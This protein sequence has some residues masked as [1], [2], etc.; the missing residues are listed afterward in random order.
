MLVG[1]ILKSLF[2]LG[3][4]WWWWWWWGGGGGGGRRRWKT[5]VILPHFVPVSLVCAMLQ[6][7]PAAQCF[8]PNNSRQKVQ[9]FTAF[10]PLPQNVKPF[11]MICGEVGDCCYFQASADGSRWPQLWTGQRW[12][13]REVQVC[14][15]ER[16]RVFFWLV[17]FESAN[18]VSHK[19]RVSHVDE[20]LP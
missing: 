1:C 14:W 6:K 19:V 5:L 9:L 12:W 4:W 11:L 17:L 10:S 13:Q 3:W 15:F 18:V 20:H 2:C 7:D 8:I 16:S